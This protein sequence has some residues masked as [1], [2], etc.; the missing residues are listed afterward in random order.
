MSMLD[1]LDKKFNEGTLT[2][3]E[4]SI[5]WV[6]DEGLQKDALNELV[7]IER[8]KEVVDEAFS[9]ICKGVQLMPLEQLSEWKGVRAWQEEYN[10]VSAKNA[11]SERTQNE[12][13]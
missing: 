5:W 2:A 1:E 7:E 8:L 6:Q 13:T 9:V 12:C 4:L 11:H 10:L 3:I